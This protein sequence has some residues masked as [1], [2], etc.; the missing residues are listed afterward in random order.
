MTDSSTSEPTI[1]TREAVP[2]LGIRTQV[3]MAGLPGLAD[4]IPELIGWVGQQGLN[5]IG[6]PFF[7]YHVIDMEGVL[8]VEVGVPAQGAAAVDADIR[9]GTIPAGRY[10]SVTHIGPPHELQAATARLL[11]WAWDRDID[12]DKAAVAVGEAWGARLEI[13]LTDPREEPDP[14]RWR[15]ELAFRLAD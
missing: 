7:R 11:E 3:P 1:V 4:R 15:T 6:A 5:L 8:D 14:A 13:Y 10:A 12:W 9:P 2:Y